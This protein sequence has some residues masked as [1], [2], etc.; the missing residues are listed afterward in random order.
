[1]KGYRIKPHNDMKNKPLS[2]YKKKKL[3]ES[4]CDELTA[5][6][7]AHRLNLDRNTVNKY[8]KRIRECIAGYREYQKMK[9]MIHVMSSNEAP[10]QAVSKKLTASNIIED[11]IPIRI[12]CIQG[13]LLTDVET[14]SNGNGS[15][16]MMNVSGYF[17]G[18]GHTENGGMNGSSLDCNDL[19]RLADDFHHFTATRFKKFFGIKNEYAYLYVKEAEFVFN[20]KDYIRRERLLHQMTDR[21]F[22]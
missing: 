12:M 2:A 4:F 20:E 5:T 11:G 8:F 10:L 3:I 13:Q 18:N 1:M 21:I 9:L 7:A 14:Q 17:N 19:N 15:K 6:Q 22:G 16:Y